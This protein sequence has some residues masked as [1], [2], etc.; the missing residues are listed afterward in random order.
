MLALDI[1]DVRTGVAV[2]DPSGTVATPVA[3]LDSAALVSDPRLV[4][5]LVEEY[6][7]IE[8]VVG[9]PLTLAGEEG[10][11]ATRV[12]ETGQRLS[13]AL[14]VPVVFWDERLSSSEASRAMTAGGTKGRA[15]RGTVDKVAAAVFLQSY[16]DAARSRANENGSDD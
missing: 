13:C 10:P 16:L 5:A 14:G 6:A 1:G 2:S 3:V 4:A 8:V 12:R 15:Q 7:A 9:L 11:Q